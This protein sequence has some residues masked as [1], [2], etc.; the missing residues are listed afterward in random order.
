VQ[1]IAEIKRRSPSRGA[2]AAGLDATAQATAYASGGAAAISVLTEPS[3]FGG[4]I[5][6]L[7]AAGVAGLPMLRKDF[8][9]DR[10]QIWEAA[11]YGASAVL[12]IARAMPADDLHELYAESRRNGLDALVEIHTESELAVAVAAGYPIVGVNNRNLETLEVNGTVAERLIP[13]IVSRAITIYESGVRGRADVERAAALGAH[14]V[15]VGSAL[16]SSPEPAL[17]VRALCGV[18]REGR[19][20]S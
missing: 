8:I 14:A 16:S 4:H 17:A 20:A 15:L 19:R 9:I 12:L 10:L 1:V 13:A 3:R 11:V 5:R 6:D 2:I 18:A 7:T